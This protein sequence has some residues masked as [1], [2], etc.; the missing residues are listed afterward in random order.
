MRETSITTHY[1]RKLNTGNYS[2]VTLSAWVTVELDDDDTAEEALAHA[3]SL[4]RE[5][6]REAAAPFTKSAKEKE[7]GT[8]EQ[9]E[10]V[11]VTGGNGKPRLTP[12]I[13]PD[14]IRPSD[15]KIADDV[16]TNAWHD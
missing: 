5:Q 3:M 13:G 4:C 7:A 1:V 12:V 6:V 2:S 8:A 9:P 14:E 10:A 15:G 11:E 16:R